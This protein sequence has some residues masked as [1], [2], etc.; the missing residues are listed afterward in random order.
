MRAKKKKV[1]GRKARG[2]RKRE[3][4]STTYVPVYEVLYVWREMGQ[5]SS[6]RNMGITKTPGFR[7]TLGLYSAVAAQFLKFV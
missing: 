4:K 2:R 1:E 7:E 5:V 6:A 3:C